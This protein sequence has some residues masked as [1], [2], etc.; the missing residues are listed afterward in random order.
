MGLLSVNPSWIRDTSPPQ[1]FSADVAIRA[2]FLNQNLRRFLGGEPAAAGRKNKGW[3]PFLP[4]SRDRIES[5]TIRWN[6]IP[7]IYSWAS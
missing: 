2:H 7:A 3:S 6:V 1:Q 4:R 5:L